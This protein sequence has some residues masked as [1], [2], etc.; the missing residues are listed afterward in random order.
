[1][2]KYCIKIFSYNMPFHD[3]DATSKNMEQ[4]SPYFPLT[5]TLIEERSE[6]VRDLI[7]ELQ[8][9]GQ[10][11]NQSL[12]YEIDLLKS[13]NDY[14]SVCNH[15]MTIT[16][17]VNDDIEH[18]K[19]R[20]KEYAIACEQQYTE[21]LD[22]H[23]MLERNLK[24]AKIMSR[25]ITSR[26]SIIRNER[27][28][29]ILTLLW[30]LTSKS[31]NSQL[32]SEY[33]EFFPVLFQ[34]I[35]KAENRDSNL[36]ALGI[37][38]N[39]SASNQGRSTLI[40]AIHKTAIP[41]MKLIVDINNSNLLCEARAIQL[42]LYIVHNLIFDEDMCIELIRDGCVHFCV[43]VLENSE[44]DIND[45]QI[46]IE[47]LDSLIS[48]K[49]IKTLNFY[50]SDDLHRLTRILT[51]ESTEKLAMKVRTVLQNGSNEEEKEK[52]SQRPRWFGVRR[53][54]T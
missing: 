18:Y 51:D 25:S 8:Y 9:F 42:A 46:A 26:A 11:T 43:E 47:V 45:K 24:N 37:L 10:L 36:A 27:I 14:L 30:S 2:I 21:L 7:N 38:V 5:A 44:L 40:S 3:F 35:E 39:I 50:S 53:I 29:P 32:I 1:M 13:Q 48:V 17:Q 20:A 34:F 28:S 54:Y 6:I 19:E 52:G 4:E 41:V 22:S 16:E 12:E 33:D 31:A 23:S 49:Y 15:I